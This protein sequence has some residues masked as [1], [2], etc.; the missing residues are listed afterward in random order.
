M[1]N[2]D[3]SMIKYQLHNSDFESKIYALQQLFP[4][5]AWKGSSF[6]QSFMKIAFIPPPPHNLFMIGK[7]VKIYQIQIRLGWFPP[8]PPTKALPWTHWGPSDSRLNFLSVY[9][10]KISPY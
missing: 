1:S 10:S 7:Q 3:W 5:K 6:M 4:F 2:R 8:A 9:N